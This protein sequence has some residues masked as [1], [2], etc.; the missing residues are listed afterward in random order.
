MT[1]REVRRVPLLIEVDVSLIRISIICDPNWIHL[2]RGTGNGL[3]NTQELRA[4]N[5]FLS[6][7]IAQ[8]KSAGLIF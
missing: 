8:G 3:Q 6:S 5:F 4:G 7:G 1:I 2:N